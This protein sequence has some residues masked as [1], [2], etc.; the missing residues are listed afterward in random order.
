MTPYWF[1]SATELA[2]AVRALRAMGWPARK[3]LAECVA[4]QEI[5]R[6]TLSQSAQRLEAEGFIFVREVFGSEYRLLPTLW[7]E[8]ALE[9]LNENFDQQ[10]LVPQPE[11]AHDWVS[12]KVAAAR[13]DTRPTIPHAEVTRRLT[14][15]CARASGAV[16]GSD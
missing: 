5:D 6:K 10:P 16:Q 14:E 12:Q 1:N 2:D 4:E 11:D 3:L 15:R 13:S 7:G 9:G 8:E